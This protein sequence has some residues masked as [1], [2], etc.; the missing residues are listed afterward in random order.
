MNT[1]RFKFRVWYQPACDG[2]ES[3]Y[4]YDVESIYDGCI[5]GLGWI[6]CFGDLLNDDQYIVEQCTGLKDKNGKLIYE[7]DIL[8]FVHGATHPIEVFWDGI[9]WK[10]RRNGKSMKFAFDCDIIAHIEMC[11]VI[12]NIH[13]ME[14]EK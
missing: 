3:R 2:I 10:F 5:D 8:V 1:D 7:G 4:F 12:G 6:S 14:I 9:G 11:E 13:R